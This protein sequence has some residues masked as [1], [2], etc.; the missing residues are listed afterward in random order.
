[1]TRIDGKL[2]GGMILEAES[3][4]GMEDRAAHSFQ[5]RYTERT[6]TMYNAGGIA[7]VYL[8]YGIHHLFNIITNIEGV[9]H[10]ILIRAIHPEIGIDTM[11]KRRH[12][13]QVDATLASGPG[14]VSQS[15]GI[16]TT[17]T[18]TDL[19]GDIIWIEDRKVRVLEKDIQVSKRIG[20]DYAKEWADKPLR[21]RIEY[22]PQRK[23]ERT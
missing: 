3:Y 23:R 5:G 16:T 10:G 20:V 8:C 9:P 7:Y 21:F 12:K 17:L 4:L 2:T 1:M 18:G 22:E 6:K 11:L 19:T 15:L 13:K 14:S